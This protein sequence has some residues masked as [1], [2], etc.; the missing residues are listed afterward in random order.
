[1][2]G[3]LRLYTGTTDQGYADAGVAG[4][5]QDITGSGP[6]ITDW[7]KPMEIEVKFEIASALTGAGGIF[8]FQEL[9]SA[10]GAAAPGRFDA[11]SNGIGFEVVN[12][13]LY[14]I[15]DVAGTVSALDTGT[16]VAADALDAVRLSSLGNGIVRVYYNDALVYSCT[17]DK[18][19]TGQETAEMTDFS[20]VNNGGGTGNRTYVTVTS[21]R[22]KR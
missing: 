11:G 3:N 16:A 14:L 13:E 2:F 18:G 4:I 6:N 19:P 8:R 10:S 7:T 22:I 17:A 15:T 5:N 9:R 20:V 21:L 1:M 12:S